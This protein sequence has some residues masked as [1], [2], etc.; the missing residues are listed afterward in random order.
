MTPLQQSIIRCAYADL[1]GAYQANQQHYYNPTHDWDAHLRTIEE[2]EEAFPE[3]LA[4]L[5]PE[6]M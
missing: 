1:L 2:M 3:L 5:I 4:D 6:E